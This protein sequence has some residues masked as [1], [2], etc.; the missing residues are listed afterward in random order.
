VSELAAAAAVSL[1]TSFFGKPMI[2]TLRAFLAATL[3]LAGVAAAQI[4]TSPPDAMVRDLT[5][6]VLESIRADKSIQGGDVSGV[7]KLV[8]EKILPH[9]DFQKMTQLAVGRGW[10]TATPE[11]RAALTREFRTLLVRTYSGALAQVKDHKVEMGPFRAQPADTDVLVRTSVVPSRGEKI[12]LDYRVEKQGD[13]WKIY[14]VNV[15]G[16]WLVENYK[17][18]FAQQINAGGIDGLIKSLTERNQQLAG[19][20]KR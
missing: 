15:L 9:V 20:G 7:Q 11:Q 17:T 14:D 5:N 13:A 18:Q 4:A 3:M 2:A 6:Q 1:R 16:V 8:D 19:A 10:R 12:Q